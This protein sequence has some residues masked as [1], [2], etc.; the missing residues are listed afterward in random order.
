M[1]SVH[2]DLLRRFTIS[3]ER[4]LNRAMSGEVQPPALDGRTSALVRIA[5]LVATDAAES[6][7]QAAVET[8]HAAGADDDEILEV[9]VALV[10]IVG[11]AR[12]SVAVPQLLRALGYE[13]GDHDPL[14]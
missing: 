11:F 2:A 6:S 10:P 9:A 1:S 13:A 7:F 12:M 14:E 3:D 5:A 8:A 4:A